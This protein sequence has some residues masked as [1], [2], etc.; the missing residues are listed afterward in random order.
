[1]DFYLFFFFWVP[2]KFVL[3]SQLILSV[4]LWR[5]TIVE[6]PC[7][8]NSWCHSWMAYFKNHYLLILRDHKISENSRYSVS[9]S[10]AQEV[11]KTRL[12]PRLCT[13]H[14]MQMSG[15][16]SQSRC[17]GHARWSAEIMFPAFHIDLQTLNAAGEQRGQLSEL[18]SHPRACLNSFR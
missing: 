17:L 12:A 7:L 10:K 9:L 14:L 1:M 2:T 5:D 16:R 6:L 4:F 15:S 3:T 18:S 8:L 11:G 13:L